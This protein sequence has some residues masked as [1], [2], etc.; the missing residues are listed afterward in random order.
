MTR[1]LDW[2]LFEKAIDMTATALRGS[3][4][5]ENSQPPKYAADLFKAIWDAL[6]DAAEDLPEKGRAG[7]RPA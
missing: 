7:I 2:Q 4:G 3:M 5:G 1:E 6:K